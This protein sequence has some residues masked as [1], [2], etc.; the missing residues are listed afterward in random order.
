MKK[1]WAMSDATADI[2]IYG[3]IVSQEYYDSDVTSKSFAEDLKR[4]NGEPVTVHINSAGGSIFDALAIYNALKDYGDV[5]IKIDG[6]AASAASM[7]AMSGKKI[8]MAENALLMIHSPHVLLTDAYDAAGL[9]AIE[10]QLGKVTESVTDTYRARI[11]NIDEL[12]QVETWFNAREA[13]AAGIVDE[14]A[15]EVPVALKG[16]TL[17]VNKLSVA[18]D[19]FNMEK[20]REAMENPRLQEVNRVRELYALKTGKAIDVLIDVALE[21]GD[22]AAQ[23]KPYLDALKQTQDYT[24]VIRDQLESGAVGVA[25]QMSESEMRA[26]QADKIIELANKIMR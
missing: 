23:V 13:L 8:V 19:K 25:G 16:R 21:R 26:A 7:V 3:D 12:I 9:K 6:L 5:T 14:I 15:G 18:A 17:F 1:F 22:T 10:E 20:I 4:F 2:Y 24:D 11:P